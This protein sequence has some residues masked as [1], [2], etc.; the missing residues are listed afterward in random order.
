MRGAHPTNYDAKGNVSAVINSSD[1]IVAA[2]GYD[3]FGN[4]VSET[5][6]LEQPYRF[7]T[8]RHY[9]GFG[10]VYYGY[11]FYQPSTGRWLT[12]DPIGEE[13][14]LNLYGFV[15]N[16]ALN[17]R[18]SFGQIAGVLIY[19]ILEALATAAEYTLVTLVTAVGAQ[20]IID[21]IKRECKRS[22]CPP[23]T[24]YPEGTVGYK[25]PHTNHDH[26]PIK[27]PNPHLNISIVRQHKAGPKKCKCYWERW[28]LGITPPPLPGWVDC[29][30]YGTGWPAF[31]N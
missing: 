7:S 11:R 4:T 30:S 14:G 9:D 13:G 18:D 10:M 21:K 24:P 2:Y 28:K 17:N 1:T 8:K 3:V 12:R 26:Y 22:K 23:C 29:N 16:N 15:G 19:P 31:S 25:G 6:T 20:T 27:A 5:G